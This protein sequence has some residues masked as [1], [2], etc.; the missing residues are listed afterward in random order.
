MAAMAFRVDGSI[1]LP[2]PTLWNVP[3]LPS[4]IRRSRS[5][6]AIGSA[7][8]VVPTP[9]PTYTTCVPAPAR[10]SADASAASRSLQ[11]SDRRPATAS[12]ACAVFVPSTPTD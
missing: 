7:S 12:R 5:A 9:S 3:A 10:A 4:A 8:P 11:P 2:V 6:N 1:R